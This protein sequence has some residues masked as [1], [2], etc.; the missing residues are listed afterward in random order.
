MPKTL[1]RESQDTIKDVDQNISSH[2]KCVKNLGRVHTCHQACP[3]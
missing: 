3:V 2:L 1:S